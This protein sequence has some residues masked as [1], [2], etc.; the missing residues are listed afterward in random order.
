MGEYVATWIVAK[1]PKTERIG[2][3]RTFL[4]LPTIC[5]EPVR[6]SLYNSPLF[7]QETFVNFSPEE[8]REKLQPLDTRVVGLVLLHTRGVLSPLDR[9]DVAERCLLDYFLYTR[10]AEQPFVFRKDCRKV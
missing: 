7:M 6:N 4:P 1:D 10:H 2:P 5:T 9:L 3:G 8:W